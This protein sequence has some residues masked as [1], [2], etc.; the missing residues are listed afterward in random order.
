MAE[1]VAIDE[2]PDL[3]GAGVKVYHTVGE[4]E[5][6]IEGIIDVEPPEAAAADLDK[7]HMQSAGRWKEYKPGW[8]EPG[9]MGFTMHY[10]A[11]VEEALRETLA[12]RTVEVWKMEWAD[13][14]TYESAGYI[15]SI[16]KPTEREGWT[17]IS[18]TIKLSG[19]PV[20]TA[21]AEPEP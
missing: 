11:T 14:S 18:V 20:F 1:E 5:T 13:G 10:D 15:K 19:E 2:T 7:S 17:Q 9:E 12:A 4:T 16:S 8:I 21:P 3:Q 6:E